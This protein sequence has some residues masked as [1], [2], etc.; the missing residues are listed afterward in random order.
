MSVSRAESELAWGS[1]LLKESLSLA[2]EREWIR[3]GGIYQHK[4]KEY[5]DACL[6]RIENWG[7]VDDVII[8]VRPSKQGKRGGGERN[9]KITLVP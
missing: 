2:P 7:E 1:T 6:G 8:S 4:K 9:E 5:G 3:R